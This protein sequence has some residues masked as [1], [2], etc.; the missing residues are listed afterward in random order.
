[1]DQLARPGRDI[2]PMLKRAPPIVKPQAAPIL[3]PA[4]R[5]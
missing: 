3:H 1:M 5:L 4:N 2:F